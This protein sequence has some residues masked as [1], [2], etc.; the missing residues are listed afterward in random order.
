MNGIRSSD[1]LTPSN[2]TI[3]SNGFPRIDGD[4]T[5]NSTADDEY[6]VAAEKN[7]APALDNG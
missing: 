2:V 7:F 3:R 4:K 5:C 1:F 6:V